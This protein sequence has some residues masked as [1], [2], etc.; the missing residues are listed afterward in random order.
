[1]FKKMYILIKEVKGEKTEK[2]INFKKAAQTRHPEIIFPFGLLTLYC[3][4]TFPCF[5]IIVFIILHNN[6]DTLILKFNRVT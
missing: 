5:I 3:L 6:F 4:C 1:M 2:E